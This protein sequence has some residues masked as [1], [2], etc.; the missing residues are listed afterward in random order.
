[1]CNTFLFLLGILFVMLVFFIHLFV[2]LYFHSYTL[3]EIIYPDKTVPSVL[4]P[5]PSPT[6]KKSQEIA[7]EINV[8]S[9]V[10]LLVSEQKF[11]LK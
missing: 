2:D 5:I 10:G 3:L 8:M 4:C 1:M 9:P 11:V 7:S 6:R